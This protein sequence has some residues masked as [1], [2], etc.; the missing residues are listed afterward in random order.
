MHVRDLREGPRSQ[1]EYSF[2]LLA[3]GLPTAQHCQ[4]KVQL[5]GQ[6]RR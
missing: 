5:V 3:E 6:A 4:L 1:G 2:G